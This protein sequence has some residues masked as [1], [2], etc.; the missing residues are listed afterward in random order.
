MR[1]KKF[2]K[3][4]CIGLFCL[5]LLLIL[6]FAVW[7]WFGAAVL[8]DAIFVKHPPRAILR[9][10][11]SGSRKEQSSQFTARLHQRFPTGTPE[12]DLDQELR[13]EGFLVSDKGELGFQRK[14]H[15]TDQNPACRDDASVYWSSNNEKQI[16]AIKGTVYWTCL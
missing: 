12:S 10:N 11:L 16:I 9:E 13:R 14:A 3:L 1:S 6:I 2:T 7:A 8:D 5:T 15:R 4:G